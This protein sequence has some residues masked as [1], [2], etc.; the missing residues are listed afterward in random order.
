MFAFLVLKSLLI[1]AEPIG[2]TGILIAVALVFNVIARER[3][4]E[5]RRAVTLYGLYVIGFGLE[6]A[7][8]ALGIDTP[9]LWLHVGTDLLLAFLLVHLA[10]ILVL[11]LTIPKV[12]LEIPTLISDIGIG[13][14]YVVA[15]GFVLS[16]AGFDP[17]SVVAASTI[18][19]GILTISMQSTLG[20]VVGGV[21]LQLDGS[22]KVGDWLQLQNGRQGRVR[23]MRWRHTVLEMRD[24]GT[25]IV[26]NA[27]LL[28]EQIIILG[29]RDG[30]PVQER[31][32]V[33]FQVDYRFS[34]PR[35]IQVVQDALR[36]SPLPNMAMDPPPECICADF[37]KDGRDSFAYY[38]VRYYLTDLSRDETTSS[39][40]RVRIYAALKRA[41]IPLA[42]PAMMV[43]HTQRDDDHSERELSVRRA[44][45]LVALRRVEL[46][47][48]LTD[49]EQLRIASRLVLAPFAAGEIMTRQGA[50][51][52]WLYLLVEGSAEIRIHGEGAERLVT[53]IDGPS[54][55]GEMGLLT[56]EPRQASVVALTPCDCFRL[57]KASFEEIVHDRPTLAAD[58]SV[59][60]ARRRTELRSVQEGF[61][62]SKRAAIEAEERARILHR[63]RDF[64]G[65]TE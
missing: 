24:W 7:L 16:N 14:S 41:Q 51:A 32:N 9:T 37:A 62:A 18:V 40:I 48:G 33:P 64:F 42:R 27:A 61:D 25:L 3:R 31:Y 23:E 2:V 57:D 1:Y 54:V 21:A 29:K 60:L 59:L 6:V 28:A 17:T 53:Q 45:G 22:V 12:G 13:F 11:D 50:V 55:F 44:R 58:L 39:A 52:H 5:L 8:P 43:F 30:K 65:L 19:A 15:A 4:R 47:K 38:V 35:V 63:V 34:P 26:P 20:N 49:D 36:N 56:G 10:A 46:F